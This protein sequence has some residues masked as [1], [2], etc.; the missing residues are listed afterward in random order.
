MKDLTTMIY[1]QIL[2]IM[3]NQTSYIISLSMTIDKD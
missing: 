1:L 2:K 3:K